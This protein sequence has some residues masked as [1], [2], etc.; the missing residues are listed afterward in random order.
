MSAV[1]PAQPVIR[2]GDIPIRIESIARGERGEH[3]QV[4]GAAAASGV[5]PAAAPAHGLAS[6]GAASTG[7]LGASVCALLFELAAMMERLAVTGEPGSIDLRSLP[8]S[9]PERLRLQALLGP[10]EVQA[11]LDAGGL[12][13]FAETRYAGLWWVEH[14]DHHGRLI[15]ELFDVS[16]IPQILASTLDE[17]GAAAAVLRASLSPPAPGDNGRGHA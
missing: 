12:S 8:M 7:G 2:L 10:G 3:T 11:T 5:P 15:S 1:P 13:T 6:G 4:H 17:I 9:P 14:R 16:P